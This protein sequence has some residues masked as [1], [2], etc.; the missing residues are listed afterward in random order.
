MDKSET[1]FDPSPAFRIRRDFDA[2]LAS[3]WQGRAICHMDLDAFFASVIELDNP[4]LKGKP[5][6]VGRNHERGV[7]ATASYAARKYGVHSA[8]S[9]V[10]AAQLCPDAIWMT[11]SGK[12]YNEVSAEV[13][14]ILEG[15]T[16]LIQRTSIDEAYFDI[17]PCHKASLHPIRIAAEILERIAELGITAS[18]GLSSSKTVSKIASDAL[19]PRG[20]TVV[21][22]GEEAGFLAELPIRKLGGIGP[23]AE[24][25]L[26]ALRIKTLGD[27]A[28]YSERDLVHILGSST[29]SF[30]ARAGGIDESPVVVDEEAKSISNEHTLLE[31]ITSAEEI[32]SELYPLAEKVGWRLRKE[33]LKGCTLTVKLRYSDFSIKTLSKTFDCA[34][35]DERTFYPAAKELILSNNVLGKK[36]RLVGIGLSNFG[37]VPEQ[38]SLFD[39]K[40]FSLEDEDAQPSISKEKSSALNE[41]IDAI[42]D[43]FG[44]D[45]IHGGSSTK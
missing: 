25:K 24:K 37:E 12:R 32:F 13:L 31:D 45:A 3:K 40:G 43:R 1:L 35:D 14:K 19:K 10:R 28:S 22:P 42:R 9:A 8:M 34:T 7:V 33:G 41:Q 20:L 30:I 23:V 17:S 36:I 5:L 27:L 2:L 4:E 15:Y 21:L 6:I 16:P 29:A 18:I 11:G 39:L 44:Y 26:Q 38:L